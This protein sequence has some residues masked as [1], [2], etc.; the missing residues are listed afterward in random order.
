LEY[1]GIK[2]KALRQERGLTQ[3]ELA[4][5]LDLVPASISSYETCGNCPSA[6]VVVKLCRFFGVSSDYLLG[7]SE[8]KDFKMTDLTDEQYQLV[9]SL[10]AHLGYLNSKIPDDEV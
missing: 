8:T 6:D 1:L 4:G 3:K 5:Y 9:A 7:L 2:L 10:I